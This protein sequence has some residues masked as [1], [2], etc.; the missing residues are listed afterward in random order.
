MVL[1]GACKVPAREREWGGQLRQVSSH[2][3]SSTTVLPAQ[4]GMRNWLA[5]SVLDRPSALGRATWW[6]GRQVDGLQS[7]RAPATGMWAMAKKHSTWLRQ[8]G[9]QAQGGARLTQ[10]CNMHE[11]A[12]NI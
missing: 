5:Q 4:K 8:H 6:P 9:I 2:K 11:H 12:S 10:S 1:A 3:C 7:R